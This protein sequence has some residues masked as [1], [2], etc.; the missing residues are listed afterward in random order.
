MTYAEEFSQTL[1]WYRMHI[2]SCKVTVTKYLLLIFL[3]AG[4]FHLLSMF[5]LLFYHQTKKQAKKCLL[6]CSL[7]QECQKITHSGL[8]IPVSLLILYCINLILIVTIATSI[9][10]Y[11]SDLP[12][13]SYQRK[14]QKHFFSHFTSVSWFIDLLLIRNR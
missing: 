1:K 4:N 11:F 9:K 5:D 2:F 7:K 10:N 14:L 6:K 13:I 3:F 12:N 8:S